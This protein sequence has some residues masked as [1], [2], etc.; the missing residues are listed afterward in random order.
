MKEKVGIITVYGEN[1][2]GNKLQNYASIKLYN[3]LGLEAET[4]K[5]I[6]SRMIL[7]K[8][9]KIKNIIKR[10]IQYIPT[11]RYIR[12]QFLKEEKFRKF[13]RFYLNTIGDYNTHSITKNILEDYKYLSVGSDQV[14]NDT[15]FNKNDIYYFSLHGV[16][17]PQVIALSPSIG[18]IS[19]KKENEIIL[20][21]ALKNYKAISCREKHGAEYIKELLG[22]ECRILIDPT[23]ALER[24]EWINLEKKPS[25]LNDT[26]YALCYFLGGIEKNKE[27]IK[28]TCDNKK[29]KIIDILD[30]RTKFFNTSPEEFIYLINNADIIFTD[31]FH[32]CVFSIIFNKNFVVYDR[33]NQESVMNSRIE[34]LFSLFGVNNVE[35]GKTYNFNEIDNKDE[36]LKYNRNEVLEYLK[37]ALGIDYNLVS[38]SYR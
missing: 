17:S 37:Q 25:W 30:K 2:F 19:L 11:H 21:E 12:Y 16:K 1:N 6:Q 13:S 33:E 38:I 29:I 28:K 9:E 34:N 24:S 22:Q 18:K 4:I 3:N 36:V 8:K 35:Y 14:W 15:D 5:V 32:A 26:K 27:I 31:S 20:K 10:V 23:M 7:N